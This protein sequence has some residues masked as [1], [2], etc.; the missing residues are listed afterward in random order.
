MHAIANTTQLVAD[1]VITREQAGIIE[2]RAR[3]IMVNLAVNVFLCFGVIAATTGLIALLAK[4]LAVATVG[5][6]VFSLGVLVLL[7]G[8]PNY[9]MLGNASALIG[10]GMLI[11]G[12][13]IELS[14]TPT[15]LVVAG[16][17]IAVLARKA[18]LS[19]KLSS[20]VFGSI[21]LMGLGTHLYG[22]EGLVYR[23][24]QLNEEFRL[25]FNLYATGAVVVAG[26][27]TNVRLI[28]ALAIIPFAN[29]LGTGSFFNGAGYTFIA[30]EST[31]TIVLMIL[32]IA[33]CMRFAPRY[34]ERTSRHLVTLAVIA[35]VVANLC[36]L[37]GT[38][39]GDYVGE[40]LWK[41]YFNPLSGYGSEYRSAVQAFRDTTLYISPALYS[42]LW[43]IALAALIAWASHRT[44]RGLFNAAL[45]F[46][47]IHAYT[48]MFMHYWTHPQAYVLGG[49]GAIFLAWGFWRLDKRIVARRDEAAQKR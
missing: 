14:G 15:V 12:G 31:L 46:A 29:I 30:R 45:T 26:W 33:V 41:V 37:V 13:I 16:G 6:A 23:S 38:L 19:A 21:L 3:E 36:A 32:L 44:H 35:F 8:H 47:S 18:M 4:P 5:L 7:R 24:N 25:L 2:T 27:I 10:A 40:F 28:S 22:L 48:Q 20:F 11:G 39:S 49:V 17:F 34:P 9:R 42:V 43:A 1:E